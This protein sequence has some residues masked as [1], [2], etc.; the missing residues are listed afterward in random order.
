MYISKAHILLSAVLSSI[1]VDNKFLD[2]LIDFPLLSFQ[3]D[4]DEVMKAF[5]IASLAH[6][7]QYRLDGSPYMTHC[8]EVTNIVYEHILNYEIDDNI[9]CAALLHDTIE[10]TCITTDVIELLN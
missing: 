4:N 3:Y 7:D 5:K 1:N 2:N 9:M 8:V 10:D 6:H